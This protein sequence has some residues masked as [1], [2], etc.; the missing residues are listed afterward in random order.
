R[1]GPVLAAWLQELESGA[2]RVRAISARKKINR[3]VIDVH[4]FKSS[5]Q[6]MQKGPAKP[7]LLNITKLSSSRASRS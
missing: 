1:G 6:R 5:E 4:R 3:C 2:F 7:G